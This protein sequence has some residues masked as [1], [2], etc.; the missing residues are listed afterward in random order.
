MDDEPDTIENYRD[1]LEVEQGPSYLKIEIAKSIN[2]AREKL[3]SREYAALVVDCRM[4]RYSTEEN[5]AKFLHYIN[6]EAEKHFPTF[7]FSGFVDE[8]QYQRYLAE[9]HPIKVVNK[10]KTS[11]ERPIAT[12]WFIKAI[13]AAGERYLEVKDYRPE[14]I[15]FNEYRVDPQK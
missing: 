3:K 1:I 4:D 13:R 6:N 5:G 14:W 2:E 8:N 9:S 7:V 15:P 12:H 11:I 10:A